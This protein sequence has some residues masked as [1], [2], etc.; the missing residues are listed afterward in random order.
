MNPQPPQLPKVPHF[1][2]DD[3]DMGEILAFP[4]RRILKSV[5]TKKGTSPNKG[6]MA[7]GRTREHL[8]EPEVKAL[9]DRAKQYGRPKFHHRNFTLVLTM[10][11]HGLRRT[12]AA[13]L[14]WSD[15]NF[16][17]GS[18][19]V[20]RVKGSKPATHPI[21]GDELRALRKLQREQSDSPNPFVFGGM[22]PKAIATTIT[23]LSTDLFAF[24]VHCHML[25]HA[26]GFYL[27]NKGIDTRTIQDYLGH[28]NITHTVR[29]TELAPG[30]FKGLWD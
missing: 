3:K 11:R 4:D 25:R 8:T 27:A 9:L 21:Q 6:N 17:D 22:A 14:R 20:R 23:R 7:T 13:D 1:D 18:L 5:P 24:P 10:Y 2:K 12:E 26:C 15:V 28:R 19:Y 29:Y 16:E 30:R